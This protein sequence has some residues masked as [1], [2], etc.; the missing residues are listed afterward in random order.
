MGVTPVQYFSKLFV[1][2]HMKPVE[3]YTCKVFSTSCA[4]SFKEEESINTY[5]GQWK[6]TPV[7][8]I[9]ANGRPQAAHMPPVG[10]QP[11]VNKNV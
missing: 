10:V 1:G 8:H 6:D 4:I 7:S 9:K 11:C 3:N 5:F 2:C